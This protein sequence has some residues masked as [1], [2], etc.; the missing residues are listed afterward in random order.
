MKILTSQHKTKYVFD[1]KVEN[2]FGQLMRQRAHAETW[3]YTIAEAKRNI[4][5]QLTTKLG[6]GKGYP[7]T[8][9]ENDITIVDDKS[10]HPLP[11]EEDIAEIDETSYTHKYNNYIIYYNNITNYYDILDTHNHLIAKN[12][13]DEKECEEYIDNL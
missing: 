1:G 6:L 3:A 9:S 8:F 10:L 11:E 13:I 5:Y 2:K 12:F 7:L 4:H